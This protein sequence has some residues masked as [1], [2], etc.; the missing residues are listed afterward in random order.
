MPLA[1]QGKPSACPSTAVNLNRHQETTRMTDR[2]V[3]P[4]G[5]RFNFA[6]HLIERNA[7]RPAKT[8]F[9]DDH[10]QLS[11]GDLADQAN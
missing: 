4:P 10:G 11:Y 6:Q 5:E 1:L 7:Q 8:A 2:H 9:I 3:P